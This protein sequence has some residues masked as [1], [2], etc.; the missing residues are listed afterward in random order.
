MAKKLLDCALTLDT[1]NYNKH[2]NYNW[3]KDYHTI[4]LCDT[5]G[6]TFVDITTAKFICIIKY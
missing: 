5:V 3:G 6:K 4:P 1:G 2:Y